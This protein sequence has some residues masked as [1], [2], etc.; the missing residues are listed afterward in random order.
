MRIFD[1]MKPRS[2]KAAAQKRER[3]L[4]KQLKKLM[5]IR[6]EETLK[7]AL[8]DDFGIR[9]KDPRYEEVLKIWREAV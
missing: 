4:A 2:G 8:E 5:E 7:K 1:E 6:D 9:P 3:D